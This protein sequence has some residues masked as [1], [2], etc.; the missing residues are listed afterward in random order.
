MKIIHFPYTP[1]YMDNHDLRTYEYHGTFQAFDFLSQFIKQEDSEA[2][3]VI[4]IDFWLAL[5]CVNIND[6]FI[7]ELGFITQNPYRIIGEEDYDG[8]I[9]ELTALNEKFTVGAFTD[10]C[11]NRIQDFWSQVKIA[12]DI[13]SV[14]SIHWVT[15]IKIHCTK[16]HDDFVNNV[17]DY[18]NKLGKNLL[19]IP[20]EDFRKLMWNRIVLRSETY[21]AWTFPFTYQEFDDVY[22]QGKSPAFLQKDDLD[23]FEILIPQNPIILL[24][25]YFL[26]TNNLT[27]FSYNP[28]HLYFTLNPLSANFYEWQ[29]WTIR[30]YQSTGKVFLND[31][32]L[33]ELH[34]GSSEF[35]F[36]KVLYDKPN[37]K[38]TWEEII[39]ALWL[40][41]SETPS[42]YI[43]KRKSDLKNLLGAVIV[44]YII[45]EWKTYFLKK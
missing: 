38:F 37:Y 22:Q 17:L 18:I 1:N 14:E 24:W 32:L 44:D 23:I 43:K 26:F 31:I 34:R 20:L 28:N 27:A 4:N 7:D 40:D 3:L 10:I 12:T 13:L 21:H 39:T 33:W 30:F 16:P 35:R 45:S 41:I 2:L 15:S 8:T 5:E 42:D 19:S 6:Y 29:E 36:F 11:I 25:Y 9:S